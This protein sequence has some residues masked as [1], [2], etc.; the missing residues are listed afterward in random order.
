M[1]TSCRIYEDL[2]NNL[3]YIIYTYLYLS[4]THWSILNLMSDT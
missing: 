1:E 4:L 3:D 2:I